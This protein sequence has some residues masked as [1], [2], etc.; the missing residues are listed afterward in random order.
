MTLCVVAIAVATTCLPPIVGEGSP[1]GRLGVALGGFIAIS[2]VG[3]LLGP[4]RIRRNHRCGRCRAKRIPY[5]ADG[6]RHD[7]NAYRTR[8][9][10][11]GPKDEGRVLCGTTVFRPR[12][13]SLIPGLFKQR[14]FC[15]RFFIGG[16]QRAQ[17]P[18]ASGRRSEVDRV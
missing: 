2:S 16:N 18:I 5:G 1:D 4:V 8:C 13:H 12:R 6:L 9:F 17:K 14:E 3:G 15:F 11:A 7:R 10:F